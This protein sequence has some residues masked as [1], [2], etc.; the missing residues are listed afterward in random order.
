[1]RI[2]SFNLNGIRSAISKGLFDWLEKESPDIFC[3]Q[4]TKAQP[5]QVDALTFNS[6]GYHHILLHSAVKKGYSGVGIFSRK[7]PDFH[8]TGIGNP[9]FDREGRVI[10]ADFG[11]L[12]VVCAYIPSG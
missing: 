11:D 6:L 2:I 4:E 7:R 10:R 12:T 5:E 3:V 8:S 1:M 9:F